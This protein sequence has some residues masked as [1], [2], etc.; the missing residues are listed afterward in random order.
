KIRESCLGYRKRRAEKTRG[1]DLRLQ[2][3][4]TCRSLGAMVHKWR[5][6]LDRDNISNRQKCRLAA[7]CD[8]ETKFPELVSSNEVQGSH[9]WC[10]CI[11]HYLCFIHHL[12]R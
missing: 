2:D 6:S 1:N 7:L 8:Q 3:L 12:A 4:P 5:V 10:F 11:E 9:F